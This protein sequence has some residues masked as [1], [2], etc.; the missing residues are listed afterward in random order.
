MQNQ[1]GS[2]LLVLCSGFLEKNHMFHLEDRDKSSGELVQNLTS[3]TPK[4]VL[5]TFSK[6]VIGSQ[7]D[8]V[9]SK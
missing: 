4:F 5:T 3:A 6:L 2:S 9:H 1:T 8:I 7:F